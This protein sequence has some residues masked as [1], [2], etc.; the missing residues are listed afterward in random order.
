MRGNDQHAWQRS[1]LMAETLE[2]FHFDHAEPFRHD[3]AG[4]DLAQCKRDW[5][6]KSLVGCL[7]EIMFAAKIGWQAGIELQAPEN[8][9]LARIVVDGVFVDD[10]IVIVL[11]MQGRVVLP[12]RNHDV[13]VQAF[14]ARRFLV[15]A[16]T[17]AQI[18]RPKA[19]RT[20]RAC[21]L[22]R[23]QQIDAIVVD[24][25]GFGRI[26]RRSR[27]A[28]SCQHKGYPGGPQLRPGA[29]VAYQHGPRLWQFA[30]AG[31]KKTIFRKNAKVNT[32]A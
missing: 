27:Q 22:W 12:A 5:W 14:I 13:K 24:Q 10:E 26:A 20:M 1:V 7:K 9:P 23:K 31:G 17:L 32:H 4:R 18:P 3:R 29:N 25:E 28:R 8:I 11:G 2:I 15:R 21:D 30:G 16:Q 19:R 6:V